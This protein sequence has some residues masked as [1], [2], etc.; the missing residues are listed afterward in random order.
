MPRSATLLT[1][2]GHPADTFVVQSVGVGRLPICLLQGAAMYATVDHRSRDD[3]AFE[4]QGD[5]WMYRSEA[6]AEDVDHLLGVAAAVVAGPAPAGRG[7]RRA[8]AGAIKAAR[9]PAVVAG[10]LLRRPQRAG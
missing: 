6:F 10:A 3:A 1:H 5:G 9:W 2:R 8:A 4:P 7:V